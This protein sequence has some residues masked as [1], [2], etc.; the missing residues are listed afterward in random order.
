MQQRTMVLIAAAAGI[1]YLI[2][3]MKNGTES[4]LASATT[5][6]NSGLGLSAWVNPVSPIPA[7]PNVTT[8]P[9]STIAP[10]AAGPSFGS[11]FVSSAPAV[12]VPMDSAAYYRYADG[13]TGSSPW[14]R[15]ASGGL[16]YNAD[17]SL[18]EGA[19][20][21]GISGDVASSVMGYWK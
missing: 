16:I 14:R 5:N 9:T 2:Y 17:G 8:A 13:S 19:F 6:L 21:G 10:A 7:N 3:R 18:S 15:D 12:T 4:T 20:M 1:G 11:S